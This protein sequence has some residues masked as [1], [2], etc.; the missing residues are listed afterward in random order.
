MV[1]FPTR[2]HSIANPVR[3]KADL[4]HV[5]SELH[6]AQ[7]MDDRVVD[8]IY[9]KLAFIIGKWFAEQERVEVEPV[10]SALLRM[11]KNLSEANL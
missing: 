5:L 4:T 8:E 6:V 10:A 3:E 7:S 9:S 11:A 2:G 1:R